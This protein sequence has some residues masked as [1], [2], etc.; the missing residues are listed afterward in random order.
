MP[1]TKR[2][3]CLANSRKL[4]GRCVAG[5]ELTE[6]G[7]AKWIRPVSA[8]EHQEVSEYERQ[9]EDG[10]DPR[11]LDVLEIPVT[12][13]QPADYQ[14][15]NWLLD[16]EQ[17][18]RK[19]GSYEWARLS[20]FVEAPITL[21]ATSTIAAAMKAVMEDLASDYD[22]LDG[23]GLLWRSDHSSF[24]GKHDRIPIAKAND[25]ISSL[26]LIKVDKLELEVSAPGEAFGSMKRRVQ[27]RFT[28]SRRQYALWVTDPAIEREYLRKAD[29][30]Y[31]LSECYLTISLGEPYK[32]FVYKMIAAVMEKPK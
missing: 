7:A 5:I 23:K 17:Y 15:E 20:R 13:H 4:Q 18:W 27:G 16:P 2:I 19:I 14:R 22:P 8:R 30:A 29:G 26:K 1:T 9:Y 21:E 10:S 32:G 31:Q 25:E 28:F 3:I 11:L 12:K 6:E 24:N